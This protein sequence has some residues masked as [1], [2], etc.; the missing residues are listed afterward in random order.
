MDATRQIFF[1]IIALEETHMM[2][3]GLNGIALLLI[4]VSIFENFKH[5]L[6][7]NNICDT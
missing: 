5:I 3:A 4:F 7:H 1:I 2:Q 6:A